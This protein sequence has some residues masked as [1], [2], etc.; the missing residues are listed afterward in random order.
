MAN[1]TSPL[2][3]QRVVAFALG[4][5]E[6]GPAWIAA[7]LARPKWVGWDRAVDQRSMAGPAPPRPEHPG[8]TL[9]PGRRLCRPPSR[10]GRRRHQSGTGR[11]AGPVSWSSWTACASA[12]SAAPRARSGRTR[13][14]VAWAYTWASLQVTRRN[15]SAQVDQRPGPHRGRRPGQPRLAAGAG[16][17]RQRPRVPLQRLPAD[18]RCPGRPPPLHPR[19]PPPKPTAASSGSSRPSWSNAGSPPSPLD[20]R[21]HPRSRPGEGQALAKQAL[22]RRHNSGQDILVEA[23]RGQLPREPTAGP[24]AAVAATGPEQQDRPGGPAYAPA[25]S[26]A[27]RA[28]G[29]TAPAAATCANVRDGAGLHT[30]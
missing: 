21:P 19:R 18:H 11:S 30:V 17:E 12:G 16:D 2:V 29:P 27:S 3:E 10:S 28:C 14:D 24:A 6:C 23:Q 13:L 5:P 20:P 25:R 15:P 8:H 9:W 4:H 22:M 1:A 26:G 7:E